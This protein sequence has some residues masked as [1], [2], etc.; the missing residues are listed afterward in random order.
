MSDIAPPTIQAWHAYM[1][2]RDPAALDALLAEDV[3]FESPVVHT[4][5]KGKA[6][7]TKYLAAAAVVLGNPSFRYLDAWYG[8]DSAVLEFACEI[9]GISVNGIDMI[10]WG[11]DG[12]IT[13]FK[14]MVRP[15]KAINTLHQAMG[16]MLMKAG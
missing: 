4:P 6:I 9:E 11:P 13:G 7:T 15:L 2:S 1:A 8:A 10:R 3:V 5:Q 12:R 16:A 14:V